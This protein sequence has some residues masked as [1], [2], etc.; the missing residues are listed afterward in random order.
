MTLDQI[1]QKLSMCPIVMWVKKSNVPCRIEWAQH[2][3]H[4]NIII[5][6]NERVQVKC[7]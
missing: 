6:E 3:I 7:A 5:E 1:Q 4:L 2:D